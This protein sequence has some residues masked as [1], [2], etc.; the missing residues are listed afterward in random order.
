MGDD[1][2]EVG[3]GQI[4]MTLLANL[5]NLNFTMQA[6]G[7]LVKDLKQRSDIIRSITATMNSSLILKWHT[8]ATLCPF[9]FPC[10][11]SLKS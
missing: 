1:D 6:L 3:K 8:Y 5:R 11:E 9:S 10:L 4:M 7:L 2:R